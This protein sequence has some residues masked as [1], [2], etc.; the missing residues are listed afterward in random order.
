MSQFSSNLHHSCSD[1][2]SV[3]QLARE[4]VAAVDMV[5]VG[6]VSD[7]WRSA[8][9]TRKCKMP[10]SACLFLKRKVSKTLRSPM[11]AGTT[12]SRA[13]RQADK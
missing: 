10:D 1:V 13:G 11:G 12:P 4:S 8:S 9:T 7:G 3:K 5:R 2:K 6:T